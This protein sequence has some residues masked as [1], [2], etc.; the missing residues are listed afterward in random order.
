MS[1]Y[2]KAKSFIYRNAR[3]VD[4]ARWQYHF[5]QGSVENVI[6]A[7]SAFQNE[8]GGFGHGLE[9]DSFN[10]NSTPIQTWNAVTILNEIG[11]TQEE[12]PMIQGILNYLDSGA[13]FD[14]KHQQW[15][16]C[17]PTNNEYPHAIWWEYKE[18]EVE[19]KYNPTAALAGF[20]L[21]Y[22]KKD[23]TLYQKGCEITKQAYD[24]LMNCTPLDD[25]HATSTFLQLYS[26]CIKEKIDFINMDAFKMKL[27]ELIRRNICSDVT[28]WKIEYVAKPSFYIKSKDSLCYEEF[29]D[30]LHEECNY[31]KNEQLA[32]GSYGL[33]WQWWTEYKEFILSANWWKSSIIIDN[34]LLLKEFE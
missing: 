14:E 21:Q 26:S 34:I 12:H 9:A 30:L 7:L 16:Y 10:P 23:S 31:V 8:D 19:Y 32:D 5:E 6:K 33:N 29:S 2:E 18:G 13:D 4:L 11:F 15:N 24:Y 28:K 22:A 3:P 27:E 20:I 1:T 25:M 17:V